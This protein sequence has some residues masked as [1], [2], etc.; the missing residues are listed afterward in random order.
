MLASRMPYDKSVINPPVVS[1]DSLFSKRFPAVRRGASLLQNLLVVIVHDAHAI[2]ASKLGSLFG[3]L[4]GPLQ[5]TEIV[6]L[7]ATQAIRYNSVWETCLKND[8]LIGGAIVHP[9]REDNK[10]CLTNRQPPPLP[11]RISDSASSER[12]AI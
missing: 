6:S 1:T 2:A 12:R 11:R 4:S 8:T 10:V 5:W 9:T 3:C 7:A